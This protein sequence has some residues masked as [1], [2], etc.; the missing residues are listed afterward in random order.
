[1]K[2]ILFFFL[3]IFVAYSTAFSQFT[4]N[5][6]V[7][8]DNDEFVDPM[9]R[10]GATGFGNYPG[11]TL[12]TSLLQVRAV[13][14]QN[15]QISQVE[16][17]TFGLFNS[18]SKWLGLGVGNPSGT[19]NPY[20]LA[21]VDSTH[22]GFYN[23]IDENS[24]TNLIAGFGVSGAD[25]ENRF[26]IRG[27]SGTG[28]A[29]G[30]DLLIANPAGGTGIN[31][32][33]LSSLWV[34][35]RESD[36]TLV[37]AIAILSRQPLAFGTSST[38]SASAIG[39]QANSFLDSVGV[40]VEGFR[41][42]IPDFLT[43]LQSSP[44]TGVATNHQA[45]ID[46]LAPDAVFTTAA[47][48]FNQYAEITWQDLDYADTTTA[49]CNML[50]IA[51]AQR[52][53]KMFISF[54]N[55]Q[56]DDPFSSVNKLPVMTFQ[57]NARVG[58][59]TTQPTSGV[60]NQNEIFLDV[61]GAVFSSSFLTP[62]DRRFKKD[63]LPIENSLELVRKLKGATYT[64]KQDEFPTRKFSGG[65][66]Y[67]FVAQELEEVIPE[68]TMINSDGFYAV[69]YTMLI[70]VLTEAI[71]EQDA[72]LTAQEETIALLQSELQDLRNQVMDLRSAD[73]AAPTKGY[74]LMQNSP[75]PFSNTT[76][77]SYQLPDGTMGASINVYDLNGRL[78]QSYPLTEARGQVD[79]KGNDLAAG[80][81][82]YDL[83]VGGRQIDV[84]RMVL[85]RLD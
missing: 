19:P 22:L 38:Q 27:Y 34:D 42:Q 23:L 43:T 83:L 28:G 49:D 14:G 58:I 81:Y 70:P 79:I 6:T 15:S 75:N 56:S 5:N 65:N 73:A 85:N 62:S 17:G 13:S 78:L 53:D 21:I 76:Q 24:K 55:N 61:N 2:R 11:S 40:A 41:A 35:A 29:F 67:G 63:I 8:T 1:M 12:P 47:I 52:L 45:V 39:V 72:T 84:K 57:A 69:N 18:T 31:A 60:C 10:T 64:Y 74:S 66:Q 7:D 26:I 77:I 20:G 37:K 30:K 80:I 54:R 50:S 3:L 33:P 59:N 32:E 25:N 16:S 46:P 68:A 48:P 71:K 36:T 4:P 44:P 9:K 51:D 82:I